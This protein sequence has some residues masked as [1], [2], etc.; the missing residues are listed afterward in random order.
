MQTEHKLPPNLGLVLEI[1]PANICTEASQF[2]SFCVLLFSLLIR[3]SDSIG[4][5]FSFCLFV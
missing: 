1:T 5:L 3:N 2:L 4:I